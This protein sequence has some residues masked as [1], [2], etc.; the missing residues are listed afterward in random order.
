MALDRHAPHEREAGPLAEQRDWDA[1]ARVASD[2]GACDVQGATMKR[3]LVS[4]PKGGSGKSN[5]ARNVAVAA[6]HEGLKVATDTGFTA[7]A[8]EVNLLP[9][10]LFVTVK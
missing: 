1:T 7:F 5:T 3:V 8:L 6:A 4:S 9:V 2:A 10:R